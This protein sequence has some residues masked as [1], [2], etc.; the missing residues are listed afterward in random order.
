MKYLLTLTKKLKLY[1]CEIKSDDLKYIDE[2]FLKLE[3][4]R[5][6]I[7]NIDFSVLKKCSN[8]KKF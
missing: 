8:L 1:D 2:V 6:S 3:T 5:L 7:N 4:L